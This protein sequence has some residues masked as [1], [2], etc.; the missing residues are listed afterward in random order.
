MFWYNIFMK[1]IIWIQFVVLLGG[2]IFAW[3]NFIME[4]NNYLAK[5]ACTLG[6]AIGTNPF[7]TPCFWGAVFFSIAFILNVLIILSSKK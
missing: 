6:C 4:L 7:Y 2:V 5:K 1:K 3:T